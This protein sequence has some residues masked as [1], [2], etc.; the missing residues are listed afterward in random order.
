MEILLKHIEFKTL[1]EKTPNLQVPKKRI[2]RTGVY[3]SKP[4][5]KFLE[6]STHAYTETLT[7]NRE[8]VSIYCDHIS[9]AK[10][11]LMGKFYEELSGAFYGGI[12]LDG[13]SIRENP[14]QLDI[15]FGELEQ[16]I[17]WENKPKDELF[18]KPDIVNIG[19]SIGEAKGC[20][21][22][23]SLHIFDEQTERYRKIQLRSPAHSVYFAIYRHA[24]QRIKDKTATIRSGEEI[25]QDLSLSTMY[26]LKIPLSILLYLHGKWYGNIK[27]TLGY[28]Y[29][30]SDYQDCT[31]AREFAI[32]SLFQ[33]PEK[34]IDMLDLSPENY[35]ITRKLSPGN[36][37]VRTSP[38]ESL[39]TLTQ[40]PILIIEDKNHEEWIDSFVESEKRLGTNIQEIQGTEEV[41][42]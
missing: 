31:M 11:V 9:K 25:I 22:G 42:F 18:I 26:S 41:P 20:K 29:G 28:R 3:I 12:V 24:F 17:N 39:T 10:H 13:K 36:F 40:F 33:D 15:D 14:A 27:E 7:P 2:K 6:E 1:I 30:K 32:R 8:E 21:S 37:T 35:K 16:M 38:A 5:K 23:S 19:K 4:L 34:I